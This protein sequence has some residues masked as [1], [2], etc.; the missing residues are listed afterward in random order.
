VA[1]RGVGGRACGALGLVEP[2]VAAERGGLVRD[3]T[4]QGARVAD[5]TAGDAGLRAARYAR[6]MTPRSSGWSWRGWAGIGAS[7]ALLLLA[8]VHRFAIG[9]LAGA[10][11]AEFGATAIEIG[12]LASL[13]FYLYGAVQI[14]AGILADT[15]G[16]RRTLAASG[17]CLALGAFVSGSA[18][19]LGTAYVGRLLVGL[20]A[21][22]IFVN[23]LR[24]LASWFDPARFATL[25]GLINGSGSVGSFL[26][27]APLAAAADSFGWRG[28][29]LALAAVTALVTALAWT[30]VRDR[31]ADD[32]R[33]RIAGPRLALA[34]VSAI[35]R[36]PEIWK[37]LVIK[38]GLD[39]SHFL[40]FAVWAVPY[41]GQVYG[42]SRAAASTYLS[43]GVVGF[44]LG[45]PLLGV[46]SDR[47][48]MSRRIP[49]LLGT[50]VFTLLWVAVL[51]PPRGA[52]GP[53]LMLGVTFAQG[54]VASSLLLTLSVARDNARPHT[55]GFATALV[56]AGGFL[57]AALFQ[58]VAS[59]VMDL[60][61]TGEMAGGA[62]VYPMAAFQV[63]F[64]GCM[65]AALVSV[66]V[67][68][69][70]RERPFAGASPRSR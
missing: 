44:A 26:A 34:D 4:E 64:A 12:V 7:A 6:A 31:P 30:L 5:G 11:M 15:L 48:F 51:V 10:L 53:A 13:Y 49:L 68:S 22:P 14:P 45:A 40:F 25:L 35:V 47:V 36:D 39:S 60:Y 70:L 42:L 18:S 56:N 33:E 3:E 62:R 61:W 27:G 20:G 17:L 50:S 16:P 8:S 2:A 65:A 38:A 32:G 41:L 59:A 63:A 24:L 28:A 69:R 66:V 55:A 23:A 21:A 52:W 1:A 67:S 58:V 37:A 57:S 46:L 54:F 29:F 43:V 19:D 9:T